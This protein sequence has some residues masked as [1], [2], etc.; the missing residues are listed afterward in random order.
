MKC[1]LERK[2]A[3]QISPPKQQISKIS[4]LKQFNKMLVSCSSLSFSS[5]GQNTR[6][7]FRGSNSKIKFIQYYN[8]NPSKPSETL[9]VR[10]VCVC[11]CMVTSLLSR[12]SYQLSFRLRFSTFKVSTTTL[13]Q[14]LKVQI[15]QVIRLLLS[16]VFFIIIFYKFF[17]H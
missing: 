5:L 14:N 15:L 10:S 13:T 9:F 6:V 7:N 2:T 1:S 11:V 16:I 8:Q 17:L 3:V 12:E 4:H